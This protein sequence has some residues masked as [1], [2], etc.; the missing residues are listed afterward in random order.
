MEYNEDNVIEWVKCS[1][2]V[3]YFASTYVKIITP[4][5]GM[6]H[7]KVYQ[8]MIHTMEFM[9]KGEDQILMVDAER[10]V[11]KTTTLLI[12]AL[13]QMIFRT[14]KTI[15]LFSFKHVMAKEL[16]SR[17]KF[18]YECLPDW[19]K[20]KILV[21]NSTNLE[22]DTGCRI[23]AASS[24][25]STKGRTI[26]LLLIDEAAFNSKLEE[27]MFM[28]YPALSCTG[29]AIFSSTQNP[30]SYFNKLLDT[31]AANKIIITGEDFH[32]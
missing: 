9:D 21:W 2:D 3:D 7:P 31:H 29:R 14:D 18:M 28:M 22:F 12:G 30:G 26:N 1:K 10:Q 4:D 23:I 24:V 6:V 11:G 25:E 20:P 16:L 19:M 15:L 8:K 5:D 32:T 17:L 13:H 27:L